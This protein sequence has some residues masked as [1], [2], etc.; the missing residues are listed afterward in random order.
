MSFDIEYNRVDVSEYFSS[1]IV[2]KQIEIS[3]MGRLG[4]TANQENE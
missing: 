4:I 3:A 1:G 2:R